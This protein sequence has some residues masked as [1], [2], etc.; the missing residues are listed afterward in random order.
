LVLLGYI[1]CY[2]SPPFAKDLY[3]PYEKEL[4]LCVL[5]TEVLAAILE[6]FTLKSLIKYRVAEEEK[7]RVRAEQYVATKSEI[8]STIAHEMRTPL[9]NILGWAELMFSETNHTKHKNILSYIL[10]SGEDLKTQINDTLD[11]SKMEAR[12]I[13]FKK[14]QLDVKKCVKQ[15]CLAFPRV[16]IKVEYQLGH[17]DARDGYGDTQ[18]IRQCLNN[19]ISNAI[20]YTRSGR[21]LLK[22]QSHYLNPTNY[23]TLLSHEIQAVSPNSPQDSFFTKSQLQTFRKNKRVVVDLA[24]PN[25][26][27]DRSQKLLFMVEIW[28]TGP[29][30]SEEHLPKLFNAF[31]QITDVPT[32]LPNQASTGLG[33]YITKQLVKLM[34]GSISVSSIPDV[35][36]IFAFTVPLDPFRSGHQSHTKHALEP[37][38]FVPPTLPVLVAEDNE[39]ANQLVTHLLTRLNCKV[40]SVHDG[41]EALD[42]ALNRDLGLI[43]M[44]YKMPKI[45]GL[46]FFKTISA[47]KLNV[48]FI[49]MSGS[50]ESST[51]FFYS[52]GISTVLLKPFSLSQLKCAIH[53]AFDTEGRKGLPFFRATV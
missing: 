46:E 48:P 38:H 32:T 28:D 17:L 41:K 6:A 47:H 51:Q 15:A 3:S 23:T 10:Q 49:L 35:G 39:V 26:K 50:D 1:I 44:D 16:N 45:D 7:R 30:I 52:E 13:I 37:H 22:V 34:G 42:I 19:F 5:T 25:E 11:L 33:L 40:I 14:D 20:K 2:F 12:E 36:S 29:G 8:L 21:V 43:I 4:S 53:Q 27:D 18:R 24:K 9:F 31:F